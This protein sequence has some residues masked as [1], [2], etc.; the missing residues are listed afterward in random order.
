MR[1]LGLKRHERVYG[2]LTLGYPAVDFQEQR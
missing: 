1:A 2:V